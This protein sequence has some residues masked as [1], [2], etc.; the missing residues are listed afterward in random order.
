MVT[1]F[2]FIRF[3]ENGG[4]ITVLTTLEPKDVVHSVNWE[5]VGGG[6]KGVSDGFWRMSETGAVSVEV[7]GPRGYLFTK[8][9]QVPPCQPPYP[10]F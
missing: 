4:C 5:S 6:M 7:K 10:K 1:Y 2:R 9:L 8:D 3:Y